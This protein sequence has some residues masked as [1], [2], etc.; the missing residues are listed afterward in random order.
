MGPCAAEREGNLGGESPGTQYAWI[1]AEGGRGGGSGS[2]K[3]VYQKAQPDFPSSQFRFFPLWSGGGGL[4]L[5]VAGPRPVPP[6][7]QGVQ[8][9]S[10]GALRKPRGSLKPG[11]CTWG[12]PVW[13]FTP[14]FGMPRESIQRSLECSLP[15]LPLDQPQSSG[16]GGGSR[17]GG[18]NPLLLW[19][20]AILMHSWGGGV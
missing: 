15:V 14:G 4:V 8:G 10:P 7:S 3:V 20:T 13:R 16:V 9:L 19:C 17:G 18:G 6:P 5:V 12:P 2:Q 1:R 11:H